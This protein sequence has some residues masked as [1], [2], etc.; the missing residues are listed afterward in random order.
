M[1]RTD[2]PL[3]DPSIE[4]A[5]VP[6]DSK[7]VDLY[8]LVEHFFATTPPESFVLEAAHAAVEGASDLLEADAVWRRIIAHLDGA[9]WSKRT[10]A[11][12]VAH[13]SRFNDFWYPLVQSTRTALAGTAPKAQL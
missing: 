4:T 8:Q 5:A 3:L 11:P 12:A 2:T 1:A 13:F 7:T 9:G 6:L 10:L